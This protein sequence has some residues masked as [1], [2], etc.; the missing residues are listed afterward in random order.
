MWGAPAQSPA[1]AP[2]RLVVAT[3]MALHADAPGSRGRV[4]LRF[5]VPD[6]VVPVW[7]PIAPPGARRVLEQALPCAPA[8]RGAGIA[9]GFAHHHAVHLVDALRVR[10]E[11]AR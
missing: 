6:A 8:A 10:V 7:V 3:P 2:R 5:C 11:L 9:P 1:L 4:D